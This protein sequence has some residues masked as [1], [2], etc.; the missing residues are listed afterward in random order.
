MK[1]TAYGV[2]TILAAVTSA[3]AS[4]LNTGTFDI[5]ATVTAITAGVGLIKAQ[6]NLKL[7]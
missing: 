5:P 6:D 2:I 3:L 7:P 4:F 1:T